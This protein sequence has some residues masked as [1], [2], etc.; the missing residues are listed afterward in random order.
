MEFLHFIITSLWMPISV[1]ILWI[2][3]TNSN[4]RIISSFLMVLSYLVIMSVNHTEKS[5]I[6]FFP[7]CLVIVY[8]CLGRK[9][10]SLLLVPISYMISVS[11]NQL[12]NLVS[13]L[14][15]DG[16]SKENWIRFLIHIFLIT[17]FDIGIS[18]I[19][20]KLLFYYKNVL[21]INNN[22]KIVV[23]VVV[24]ITFST[25]VYLF[26]GWQLRNTNLDET[27][28]NSYR[29]L[30][31]GQALVIV[32]II[33]VA[34][35]SIQAEERAK[36]E[37]ENKKNLMAYTGQIEN[38]YNELRSF[39]HDYVNMLLTLSGYIDSND[40]EGLSKYYQETILPT[41]EKLNQGKYHLHKL[42]KIQDP[43]IKG[44]LSSKFI[45]ALNLGIDLFVD[46]MDEIPDIS[47]KVLDLTR[48]LGIYIDNAVEAALETESKE[49]KFNVVLD[50]NSVVIVIANSYINKGISIRDID[51][52]GVSTK[53]D[54]RG[55][56]LS[57][58][59]EILQEYSNVNKMTE[60]KDNYF[61][62]TL[63]IE[64]TNK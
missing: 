3:K 8:F 2:K 11:A 15:W 55:I 26:N 33:A 42:S 18:F 43:A 45:N 32:W 27:T 6:V 36:I 29:L 47:M 20:R 16:S 49:V 64:N 57:N 52:R 38:M 21:V 19:I 31:L 12:G 13:G 5:A 9:I 24:T 30:Y 59:N 46:I 58:V 4:R 28:V 51:G 50:A 61:I 40:M 48:I 1:N 35:K 10:I 7:L 56:G 62:Q 53:G 41:N 22:K 54:G 25:L 23:A 63:I 60:M 14:L 39:K 44:L 37:E 34:L 17:T